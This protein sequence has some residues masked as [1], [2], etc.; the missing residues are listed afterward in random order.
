[1]AMVTSAVGRIL[2]SHDNNLAVCTNSNLFTPV[3]SKEP[4]VTEHITLDTGTDK[5]PS[6]LAGSIQSELSS[7]QDVGY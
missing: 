4:L 7:H 3:L 6:F 5:D 1:M 2:A